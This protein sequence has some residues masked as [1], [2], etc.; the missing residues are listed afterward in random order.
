[1][2]KN[3]QA[4]RSPISTQAPIQ[5]PITENK[6]TTVTEQTQENGQ[7][8]D[9]EVTGETFVNEQV[10]DQVQDVV[11]ES[12]VT[13]APEVVQEAP[14]AEPE[15]STAPAEPAA[16]VSQD[17][18]A[19]F[20]AHIENVKANGSLQERTLITYLE[21]YRI[22]MAPGR[23]VTEQSMNSAQVSL[24]RAIK[25]VL[26]T[27]ENFEKT[28]TLL[29]AYFRNLKANVFHERYVFRGMESITLDADQAKAF[30]RVINLLKVAAG[31]TSH[32]ATTAQVDLG[33]TMMENVFSGDARNRV[34]SYFQVQ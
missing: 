13:E 4:F 23:P 34:M 27:E 20:N 30:Q 16:E 8:V 19:A 24:W 18:L 31:S 28:F 29:I 5:E 10:T 32:R 17:P 33:R 12:N 6:D 9:Q 3:R 26:E 1:M 21:D 2:A 7:P 22:N 15:Q 14:A 25:Q 11:Q